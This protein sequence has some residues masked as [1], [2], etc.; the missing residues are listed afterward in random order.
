MEPR[1]RSQA[2][3]RKSDEHISSNLQDARATRTPSNASETRNARA[4]RTPHA[5]P[6][7]RT[8]SVP[9]GGILAI[10]AIIA[11]GVGLFLFINPPFIN[12]TVNGQQLTVRGGST[13]TSLIDEGAAAPAAG[14]LL[15]VDGSVLQEGG[16]DA[17]SATINGGEPTSSDAV[18]KGGDV[19]VI[20]NGLDAYEPS[21]T[22]TIETSAPIV[23]EGVG[24]MHRY[25]RSNAT[26]GKV[27]RTTGEM[28]GI[29]VDQTEEPSGAIVFKYFNIDAAG[30]PVIALTF[31]D[32]PWDTYTGE[33][34]D[35]LAENDAKATFF[36]VG[37]R[38]EQHP[39]LTKRAFDEGHQV[40]T[41]TYDH[42]MGS[43]EGV[44]LLKMSVD[45]QI[46]EVTKGYEAISAATG[47]EASRVIRAPGGNFNNDI[48]TTLEPYIDAEVGW[49]VDTHDWKKPGADV[50]AA[51]LLD[52]RSGSIVLM[53]DGGG[54]RSQTVEALKTAL[55]QLKEQGF[56]FVTIDELL[57][58][59]GIA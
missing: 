45:E 53:H 1:L 5:A 20:S 38:V 13:L 59:S 50:I 57:E 58:I 40:C 22:E 36:T 19:V 39:E 52:V 54:D 23:S 25:D 15:A 6:T 3:E 37:Y 18:L 9:V 46:S 8:T 31:D 34:L 44:S 48:A 33:I 30:E 24:A 42:A 56:R 47:H 4:E 43:G 21:H 55:P 41:H 32:G 16:G 2:P 11:L 14:N 35:I 12:V 10:A 27:L 28:S 49:N 17:F 7:R 26:P 29:T 51:R